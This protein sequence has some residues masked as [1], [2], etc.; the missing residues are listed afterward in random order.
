M[1]KK[2]YLLFNRILDLFNS[3]DVDRSSRNIGNQSSG[4][5]N[6]VTVGVSGLTAS[7]AAAT[8]KCFVFRLE[9]GN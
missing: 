3:V 5:D 4:G 1:I 2:S 7:I 9:E 6:V 8:R